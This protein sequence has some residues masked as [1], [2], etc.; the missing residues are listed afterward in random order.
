L[1]VLFSCKLRLSLIPFYLWDRQGHYRKA[2]ALAAL[3][4]FED[5]ATAFDEAFKRCPTDA[6]LQEQAEEMRTKARKGKPQ[7]HVSFGLEEKAAIPQSVAAPRNVAPPAPPAVAANTVATKVF[8]GSIM[9][10]S[11]VESPI[12]VASPATTEAPARRSRFAGNDPKGDVV[13]LEPVGEAVRGYHTG[14]YCCP[15]LI[16]RAF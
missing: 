1:D 6:K 11:S 16:C 3:E 5:A 9:E 14:A 4:R 10:R 8:T 7:K 13:T 12:E 2:S 15:T